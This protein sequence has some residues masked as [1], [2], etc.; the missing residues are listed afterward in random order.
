MDNYLNKEADMEENESDLM[1]VLLG[2]FLLL[3]LTLPL[4][5][6]RAEVT[7]KLWQWFAEERTG[8]TF[9]VCELAGLWILFLLI[10]PRSD[11]NETKRGSLTARVIM[12]AAVVVGM[13]A[14]AFVAGWVVHS[15]AR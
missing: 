9:T 4:V 3:V 5:F 6:L 2:W 1:D 12:S 14:I 7:L 13:C 10:N 15:I 8:I 11:D